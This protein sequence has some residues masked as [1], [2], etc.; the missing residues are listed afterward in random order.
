[1]TVSSLTDSADEMPK[2]TMS[3]HKKWP[4]TYAHLYCIVHANWTCANEAGTCSCEMIDC[5]AFSC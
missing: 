4:K 2:S 5:S 1:M 3:P